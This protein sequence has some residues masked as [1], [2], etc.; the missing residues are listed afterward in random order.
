MVQNTKILTNKTMWYKCT[1]TGGFPSQKASNAENVSI[2]WRRRDYT[3]R[4]D[5]EK[6]YLCVFAISSAYILKMALR[7]NCLSHIWWLALS[8]WR[9]NKL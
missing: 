7:T 6:Y 2:W 8:E 5:Y 1:V 9:L 4:R 3:S